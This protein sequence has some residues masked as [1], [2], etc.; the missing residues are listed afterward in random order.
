MRLFPLFA[1]LAACPAD[2]SDSAESTEDAEDTVPTED[3]AA[4]ACAVV[5]TD[6]VL[7]GSVALDWSTWAPSDEVNVLII[8]ADAATTT[9]LACTD[10][11]T[12][13]LLMDYVRVPASERSTE[14]A[15][16]A[17]AGM[18]LAISL[19]DA[20]GLHMWVAAI[21]SDGAAALSL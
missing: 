3:T 19:T 4:D 7:A 15:L 16:D 12:Q 10:T 9:D 5:A 17:Y 1:L 2:P 21:A 14:V 11:L 13:E 8:G 6:A 18:S 20:D